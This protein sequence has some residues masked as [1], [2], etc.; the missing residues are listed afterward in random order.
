LVWNS[1]SCFAY[2][3]ATPNKRQD[4]AIIFH[5]GEG[6]QEVP[7]IGYAIA[8]DFIN[9]PPGWSFYNVLTSKARPADNVW[10]D[11][12][13]LR[14]FEPAQELWVGASHYIRKN[15]DCTRCSNPVYFVFGRERDMNNYKRWRRK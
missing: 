9:A 4:L 10:G 12:N 11:Y 2:P 7:A 6:P 15:E 5:Y 3:S 13:T 8:D 14:E 1:I